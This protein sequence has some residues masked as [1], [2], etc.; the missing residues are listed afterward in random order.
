MVT[1]SAFVGLSGF[2]FG[3]VFARFGI[4]DLTLGYSWNP[5]VYLHTTGFQGHQKVKSGIPNPAKTKQILKPLNP[6]DAELVTKCRALCDK[7]ST[8]QAFAV[9]PQGKPSPLCYTFTYKNFK[10]K[11]VT[12]ESNGNKKWVGQK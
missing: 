8:C 3:F 10:N 1:S 7:R 4:P 5:V 12:W 11:D 9:N 6:T 2:S